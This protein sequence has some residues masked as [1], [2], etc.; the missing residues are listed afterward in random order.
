MLPTT[1]RHDEYL[2]LRERLGNQLKVAQTF[3]GGYHDDFRHVNG[4]GETK[5]K[6][7]VNVSK[8]EC[9]PIFFF[10]IFSPLSFQSRPWDNGLAEVLHRTSSCLA[11]QSDTTVSALNT[12]STRT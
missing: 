5:K 7:S 12:S 11:A 1:R 9:V 4:M 6:K 10:F 2:P 8:H 3:P